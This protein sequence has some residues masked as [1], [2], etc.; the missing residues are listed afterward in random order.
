MPEPTR[1]QQQFAA[2]LTQAAAEAERLFGCRP[3][4]FAQQVERFGAVAATKELLRR[5][6]LSERFDLLHAHGRLD[7]SVE[8]IVVNK[9]FAALFEDD[10]V[11]A[12]FEV[13]CAC[14][15]Y[16]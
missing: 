12:C 9:K 8:A 5:Q 16:G 3:G 1:Q 13:L 11:N 10:E 4:R 14:G 6:Q 15:Y 7:L 2:A